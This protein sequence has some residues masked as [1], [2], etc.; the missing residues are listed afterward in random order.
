MALRVEIMSFNT[1]VTWHYEIKHYSLKRVSLFGSHFWFK[2]SE[3]LIQRTTSVARRIQTQ[4]RIKKSVNIY[5]FT[6][7]SCDSVSNNLVVLWWWNVAPICRH[8]WHMVVCRGH[9]FNWSTVIIPLVFIFFTIDFSV[10]NIGAGWCTENRLYFC[11]HCF[12]TRSE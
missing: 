7:P 3:L 11:T 4:K 5:L 12:T 6:H 1:A 2:S 10:E 9:R 8:C